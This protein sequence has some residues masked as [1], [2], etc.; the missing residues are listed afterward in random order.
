MTVVIDDLLLE[1]VSLLEDCIQEQQFFDRAVFVLTNGEGTHGRKV[2]R[3]YVCHL[4]D[5]V[6]KKMVEVLRA[7]NGTIATRSW[8]E[9]ERVYNSTYL[10]TEE[11]HAIKDGIRK[12]GFGCTFSDLKMDP[13]NFFHW[14]LASDRG[15]RVLDNEIAFRCLV[16]SI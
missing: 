10:S 2:I 12:L 11:Q 13:D 14:R 6:S 16:I 1:I 3:P 7:T 15:A 4:F 9:F 8:Y 5:S